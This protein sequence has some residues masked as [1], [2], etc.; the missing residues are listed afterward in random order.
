M[1]S[2]SRTGSDFFFDVGGKRSF[3]PRSRAVQRLAA[4]ASRVRLFSSLGLMVAP[5]ACEPGADT[6]KTSIPRLHH[7]A[8][9]RPLRLAARWPGATGLASYL[10]GCLSSRF[11][12]AVFTSPTF[13][14]CHGSCRDRVFFPERTLNLSSLSAV[15]V[16]LISLETSRA[17]RPC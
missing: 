1:Q 9:G 3:R 2:C 5:P 7:L 4:L 16:W 10:S 14:S 15:L 6:L 17:L 8:P 12:G 13:G 11:S